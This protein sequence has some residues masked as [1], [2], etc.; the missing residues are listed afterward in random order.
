MALP[1]TSLYAGILALFL[2]PLTVRVIRQ[3]YR[4]RVGILDGGDDILARAMRV[5]GNFV[6][7][8]PLA[9]LLMALIEGNGIGD[10]RLHV[11]G[12]VLVG[13]RMLHAYGLGRSSGATRPRAIGM[14]ATLAV[15]MGGGIT[16][17]YQFAIA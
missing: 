4:A 14:M 2:V 5:H 12:T 1:I 10:W 13:G 9:L 16:A 6:E 11:L 8:V 3:R 15:I 7:Y 17:L